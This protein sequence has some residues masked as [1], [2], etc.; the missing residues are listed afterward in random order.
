M[1]RTF[2]H[3]TDLSDEDYE[4]FDDDDEDY[5]DF[6]DYAWKTGNLQ[7]TSSYLHLVK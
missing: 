2:T 6:Y 3:R 4:P 1:S 7:P 5:E